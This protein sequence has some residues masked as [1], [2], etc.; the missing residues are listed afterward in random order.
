MTQMIDDTGARS[1]G[2]PRNFDM[3]EAVDRAVLVF[4]E[5]GY[6][7][8]SIDIISRGTGLTAGSLYKAFKDKK[9]I[10]AAAFARY[11]AQRLAAIAERLADA[12]SGRARIAAL[13]DLYLDAASGAEGERGCLVVASLAEA[14]GLDADQRAALAA[15]IGANEARLR[16]LLRQGQADG[17]VRADLDV[18]AAADV[19]LALLQGIRLL[20]KLRPPRNRAGFIAAALKILD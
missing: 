6:Q 11:Q 2:R 14:S 7:S 9:A 4:R 16:D 19:L 1:P 5:R 17:S 18:A 10:F 15:A 12:E 13:L 20:G 8:A 3:A